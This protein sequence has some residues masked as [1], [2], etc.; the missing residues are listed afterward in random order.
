MEVDEFLGM[1][2]RRILSIVRAANGVKAQQE[3]NGNVGTPS[4]FSLPSPSRSLLHSTSSSIL[5]AS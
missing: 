2:L 1:S 5:P 4:S 3:S